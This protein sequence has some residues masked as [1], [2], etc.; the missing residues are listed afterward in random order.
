MLHGHWRHF[1]WHG[2]IFERGFRGQSE[3]DKFGFPNEAILT[4]IDTGAQIFVADPPGSVL[5]SYITSGGT[6]MERS[7]SSITEGIGQGR[8]TDNMV[9]SLQ[10]I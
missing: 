8:I 6:K 4:R 5:Y 7:G 9:Q 10:T 2:A 3:G 1:S